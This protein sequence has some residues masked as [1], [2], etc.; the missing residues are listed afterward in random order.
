MAKTLTTRA[1]SGRFGKIR[2][3]YRR[4]LRVL[5]NWLTTRTVK[6]PIAQCVHY[7]GFRYGHNEYNPYE[8]YIIDVSRGVPSDVARSRF[9]E[10][11]RHY[12]PRHFGEALGLGDMLSRKYPLWIFP[13][14]KMDPESFAGFHGWL[15][16]P[17]ECP[18]ILTHFSE[19]GI[20][21]HRI[22]EEFFWLERALQS[23]A[24]K[25]Y[26]PL[27][28][29]SFVRSLTLR[30]SD[31]TESYLLIDG[32]HRVSAMSALGCE[33]VLIRQALEDRICETE[34]DEWY[35]VRNGLFDR[36]DAL[37][38]FRAYFAGNFNYRTT[39]EPA[40]ILTRPKNDACDGSIAKPPVAK[41]VHL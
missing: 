33:S 3:F 23:I 17:E 34:C 39:N 38:I 37:R 19:A 24:K 8:S 16:N 29:R 35:G 21:F 1:I 7:C 5:R 6:A 18:D 25:G 22:T 9:I 31:G 30:R 12:R 28:H 13:W 10:F 32:N 14:L 40:P 36:E 11:L 15:T 41:V 27:R 26:Q 4:P 20:A 2:P